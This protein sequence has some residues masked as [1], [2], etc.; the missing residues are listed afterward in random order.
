MIRIVCPHCGL[1]DQT[2]FLYG[3]DATVSRPA[4]DAPL[5]AWNDYVY[6]RENPRG[7][8]IELWQH[9][10]GCREWIKVLRDVTTHEIVATGV[11]TDDLEKVREKAQAEAGQ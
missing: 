1:R 7:L 4:D 9:T 5:D 6:T 2:E 10:A 8:H 3:G 11:M